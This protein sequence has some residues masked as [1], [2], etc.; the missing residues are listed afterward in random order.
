MNANNGEAAV[1]QLDETTEGWTPAS[2]QRS[3][4][5]GKHANLFAE[6]KKSDEADKRITHINDNPDLY[7]WKANP[8]LL[9]K[10]HP[11]F[12]TCSA[13]Q[14]APEDLELPDRVNKQTLAQALNALSDETKEKD[15]NNEEAKKNETSTAEKPKKT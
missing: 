11:N 15:K 9:Q 10:D 1:V 5:R 6:F 12:A 4:S 8:C 2:P 3:W 14:P 13:D 7:T